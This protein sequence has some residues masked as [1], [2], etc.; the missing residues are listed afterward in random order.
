[1]IELIPAIDVI[2]G[3]CVR[4]T[5]GDY[6]TKKIYSE[7][8]LEIAKKYQDYGIRRLHLVD[9]D[10]AREG[11]IVNYHVLERIS[12]R[13][14]LIIDFGGGVKQ[15]DDLKVAFESG[16]RMVTG[17]SIAVKDPES[18]I[19]WVKKYGSAKIIL[20]AD[21]KENM[22]AINGWKETTDK[23]LIPFLTDYADKGITKVISTD[24]N[25][26][27]ML[28]GPAIELYQTIHKALPLLYVIASGGVGNINDIKK[29]QEAGVPA[30]IF[31]KALYEGKITLDEL[32]HF[33]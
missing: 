28:Q 1:M 19:G 9:L 26:D 18:F 11:H 31:G 12:E 29:L 27:G 8:P 4:L 24:I 15:E 3:K 21:V 5:K 6:N 30:V 2:D 32:A 16:A 20:G 23:E 33:S 17:G 10:G 7:D 25:Y 22:I 14:T 13:T